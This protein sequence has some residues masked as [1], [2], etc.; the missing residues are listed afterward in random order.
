MLFY[1]TLISVA[2]V[3]ML[4]SH[5]KCPTAGQFTLRMSARLYVNMKSYVQ[6]VA[7]NCDYEHRMQRIENK[8]VSRDMQ[9]Q[10]NLVIS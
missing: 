2:C 8:S 1:P 4:S 3:L 7:S 10:V 9:E 6:V 5:A